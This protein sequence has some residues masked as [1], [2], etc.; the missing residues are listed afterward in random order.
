MQ[1]TENKPSV[2]FRRIRGHIVPIRIDPM[3]QIKQSEGQAA[4]TGLNIARA[5]GA[6]ATIGGAVYAGGWRVKKGFDTQINKNI[7]SVNA[8]NKRMGSKPRFTRPSPLAAWA[9]DTPLSKMAGA[10][11]KNFRSETRAFEVAREAHLAKLN[12]WSDMSR[13]ASH[14]KGQISQLRGYSNLINKRIVKTA[15]ATGVVAAGLSLGYLTYTQLR[16]AFKKKGK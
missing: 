9:D 14:L 2:M 16:D 12:S 13:R 8:I 1:V 15:V 11:K 7:K 5:A 4:R 3:K 6:G 10:T